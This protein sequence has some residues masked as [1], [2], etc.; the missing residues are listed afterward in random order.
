VLL[1]PKG[2]AGPISMP[3]NVFV[4]DAKREKVTND[5]V[6][7]DVTV[8]VDK[9]IGYFSVVRTVTFTVPEGARAG[10]FELFVGF[11]RNVPG[12]G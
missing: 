12:A 6:K 9:P 5:K 2:Q 11:E 3:L 1:G 8:A 7:V 4:T 10:E